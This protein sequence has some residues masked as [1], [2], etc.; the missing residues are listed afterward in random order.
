LLKTNS[1]FQPLLPTCHTDVVGASYRNSS[2]SWFENDGSGNF[3]QHL[4][5]DAAFE[6]QHVIMA[7]LDK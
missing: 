1:F 5:S 4:I 7:D 3:T 2:I 6:G